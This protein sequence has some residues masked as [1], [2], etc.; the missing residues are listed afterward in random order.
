[1]L[2][3][4]LFVPLIELVVALAGMVLEVLIHLLAFALSFGWLAA[5]SRGI[6]RA[7]YA[8]AALAA[9][10]LFSALMIPVA[11]DG[12]TMLLSTLYSGPAILASLALLVI[13]ATLP[14]AIGRATDPTPA[15]A[16]TPAREAPLWLA[17]VISA[18]VVIG[19][20][21]LWASQSER[22]EIRFDLC[23]A[24]R[25]GVPSDWQE[26]GTQALTLTERLLRREL[27]ERL[28]CAGDEQ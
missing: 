20:L 13:A 2:L 8:V 7:S 11:T 23:E 12:A 17:Y 22:R 4:A 24:A 14:V 16:E 19:G 25:K 5:R 18:S 28:P 3:D 1:M 15:A 10:H 6:A 27:S 21:S 9:A 26:R